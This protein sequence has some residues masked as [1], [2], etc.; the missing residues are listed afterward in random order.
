MVLPLLQLLLA[1]MPVS[2][3]LFQK[4]MVVQANHPHHHLA[5]SCA[6]I[7]APM[8]L[9]G[10]MWIFVKVAFLVIKNTVDVWFAV[11]VNFIESVGI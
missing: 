1:R 2:W 3:K 4:L 9:T 5:M 6:G 8:T 10:K 7:A 11:G